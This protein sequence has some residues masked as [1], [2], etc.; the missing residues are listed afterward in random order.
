MRF[1]P[2]ESSRAL[3]AAGRVANAA[4]FPVHFGRTGLQQANSVVQGHVLN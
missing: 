1:N 4:R 2:H 3:R